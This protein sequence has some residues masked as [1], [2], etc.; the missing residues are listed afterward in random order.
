M[1]VDWPAPANDSFG[2]G[3][4]IVGDDIEPGRYRTPNDAKGSF[5]LCSWTRL[6]GLSGDLDDVIAIKLPSGPTYVEILPTDVAFETDD[7]G[8]WTK[9][10]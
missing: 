3:T 8:L 6:S 4:W 2:D 10:E 5:V 7:C 9:V 1:V